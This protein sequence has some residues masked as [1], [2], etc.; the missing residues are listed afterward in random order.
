MTCP[1]CGGEQT[2]KISVRIE[3]DVAETEAGLEHERIEATNSLECDV[4][5]FVEQIGNGE[6]ENDRSES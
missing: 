1:K 2:P 6:H 3:G 5:G 4:C